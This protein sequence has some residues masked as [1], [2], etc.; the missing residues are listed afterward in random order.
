MTQVEC[1]PG[2]NGMAR[3]WVARLNGELLRA[4]SGVARCFKTEIA[5]QKALDKASVQLDA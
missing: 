3:P 4:R 5:A 2:G 1:T